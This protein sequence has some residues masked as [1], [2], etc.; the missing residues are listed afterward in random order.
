[1]ATKMKSARKP[2]KAKGR[3]SKAAAKVTKKPAIKLVSTKS[4]INPV[5]LALLHTMV[6][7]V[8]HARKAAT[9]AGCRGES[10]G[11]VIDGLYHQNQKLLINISEMKSL[12][13][14]QNLQIADLKQNLDAARS[15]LVHKT[16]GGGPMPGGSDEDVLTSATGVTGAMPA[17]DDE[18][19]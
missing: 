16:D 10:L 3:T 5:Q 6:E 19:L 15:E 2:L 11:A 1:M 12:F 9:D 17:D 14:S 18:E 4:K 13:E 7:E 8:V